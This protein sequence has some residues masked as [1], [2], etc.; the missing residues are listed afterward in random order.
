MVHC[1]PQGCP[2]PAKPAGASFEPSPQWGCLNTP[3]GF[4][5][6]TNKRRREAL[7]YLTQLILDQFRNVHQ[8]FKVGSSQVSSPVQVS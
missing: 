2:Q 1:N 5:G 6:G 4:F 7:P 3:S 8:N